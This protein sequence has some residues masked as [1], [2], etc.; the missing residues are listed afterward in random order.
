MQ[1][2]VRP[3][4]GPPREPATPV[5]RRLRA[6]R[7]LLLVAVALPMLEAALLQ[8]V[9]LH[10]SVGLSPQAVAPGPYGVFHD[11]RWLLVYH[12]S[13]VGFALEAGAVWLG[14]SA[15]SALLLRAAWADPATR[16]GPVDAFARS[17]AFTLVC[18]LLL[19]PFAALMFG[20]AVASV[21]WLVFAAV[22]SV[23][24]I[25]VFTGHGSVARRWY[26]SAPPARV[27]GWM[28][29]CFIGYTVAAA[30]LTA[31]PWPLAVPLAGLAGLFDA[32]A[33]HG[34]VRAVAVPLPRPGRWRARPVSTVGL[35][36]FAGVLVTGTAIGFHST[37]ITVHLAPPTDLSWSGAPPVMVVSGFGT[38]W[39]G[40]PPHYLGDGFAEWRFSYAGVSVADRPLPY[41]G[42]R[43]YQPLPVLARRMAQQVEL[44]HRRTGQ[45]VALVAESEGALV[46]EAYLHA[47]PDAP[48]NRLVVLS[49]LV[50]PGRV[51]YPPASGSGYGVATGWELRGL[52][53]TLET[54]GSEEIRGDNPFL[55]SVADHSP[56]LRHLLGCPTPGVPQLA[57]LPLADAASTPYAAALG[58]PSVVVPGFHGGLLG[59]AR[60]QRLVAGYLR[61]GTVPHSRLLDVTD[62]AIKAAAT[63]WQVPEL[64][65]DANPAWRSASVGD[66]AADAKALRGWVYGGG[67][68]ASDPLASG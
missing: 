2:V 65:V 61:T 29:L 59:E 33:W 63:A 23:L 51:Y 35:L 16:P 5:D 28:V 39:G 53:A 11:L 22:P 8:L 44:F 17:A 62:Q 10:R 18:A 19:T 40:S 42:S 60:V 36:A 64:P 32:W 66:C 14:R 45:P 12:R 1:G 55:R 26:A 49:P 9:H 54:L 27:A 3:P 6:R 43:T 34:I 41:S 38:P 24:A 56:Q 30:V 68:T 48:V 25:A 57:V 31:A 13:M 46:A 4:T 52:S 37:R 7:T 21:S 50:E 20:V 58:I 47:T 15:L 67:D